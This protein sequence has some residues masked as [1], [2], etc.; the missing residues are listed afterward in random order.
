MATPKK[1]NPNAQAPELIRKIQQD[2][3]WTQ[4][5]LEGFLGMSQ[6]SVSNYYTGRVDRE[7]H[8]VIKKLESLLA[9]KLPPPPSAEEVINHE[10]ANGLSTGSNG[11]KGKKGAQKKGARA[12]QARRNAGGQGKNR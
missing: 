4:T 8:G 11:T 10:T 3:G 9:K 5:D 2:L 6:Q 7:Q 12:L 1:I